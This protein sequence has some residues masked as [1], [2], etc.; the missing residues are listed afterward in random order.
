MDAVCVEDE[1]DGVRLRRGQAGG[2]EGK[3]VAR[4]EPLVRIL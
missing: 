1:E 2:G 4:K 3:G